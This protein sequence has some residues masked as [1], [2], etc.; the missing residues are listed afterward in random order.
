MTT[1]RARAMGRIMTEAIDES[2]TAS[3]HRAPQA[4]VALI[5]A[6]LGDR[7]NAMEAPCEF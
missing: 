3:A 1:I 2:Q 5:E 6:A 4:G 7:E